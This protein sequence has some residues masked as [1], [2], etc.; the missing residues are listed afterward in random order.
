M[1]PRSAFSSDVSYS[2]KISTFPPPPQEVSS[3]P[4]VTRGSLFLSLMPS[5]ESLVSYVVGQEGYAGKSSWIQATRTPTRDGLVLYGTPET[6]DLGR[7]TLLV[8]CRQ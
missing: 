6:Q 1:W 4:K 7:I 3:R 5:D 2:W 8:R